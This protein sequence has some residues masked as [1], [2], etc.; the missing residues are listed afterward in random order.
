MFDTALSGQWY[1]DETTT[2][3]PK[4]RAVYLSEKVDDYR[5]TNAAGDI[6]GLDGFTVEQLRVSLGAELARQYVLD[7]ALV[8][9]PSVALTGGYSSLGGSGPFGSVGAGLTLSNGGHW[10]LDAALR[11][12]IEGDGQSSAGG[13]VGVAVRF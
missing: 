10:S 3:S 13:R 2:L 4:L 11:F 8:L 12:N 5:V 9:T 6:V 7:D 1:L